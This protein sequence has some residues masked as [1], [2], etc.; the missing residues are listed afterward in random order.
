VV[1]TELDRDLVP[2]V[3]DLV[4]S[5]GKTAKFTKESYGNYNP[6]DGSVVQAGP[7]VYRQKVTPPFPFTK[8]RVDGDLI[9]A[10]D[11]Q[12]FLPAKDLK[13]EPY[14][15]M[16]VEIDSSHFTIEWQRPVYT[17]ELV[18]MYELALRA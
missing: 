3:L 16:K 8:D 11:A 1:E 2:A 14:K 18:A 17:G 10:Q 13:F 15:G 6:G 5:L 12:V 4:N 9:R 7:M